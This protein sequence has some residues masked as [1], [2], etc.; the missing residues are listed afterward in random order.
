M[1]DIINKYDQETMKDRCPVCKKHPEDQKYLMISISTSF[2][3]LICNVCGVV[4]VPKSLYEEMEKKAEDKSRLVQP[5][6]SMPT[7]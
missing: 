6:H 2:V 5:V 1:P 7:A 3:L 4:Y